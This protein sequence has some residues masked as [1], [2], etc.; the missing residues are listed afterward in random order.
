MKQGAL[1]VLVAALSAASA[2]AREVPVLRARVTDE[3]GVLGDRR[4]ALEERLAAYERAT[5]HQFAVL[6]LRSL[7]GEVL[8]SYS[9]RVAEA[10]RLGDRRRDDGL[11][12]LVAVDDRAARIEVG[13]GLEG[14]VPDV[15]AGRVMREHMIP[16]FKNGDWA[17]G[18]EA[19]LDALMRAAQGEALGPAPAGSGGLGDRERW[20]PIVFFAVIALSVLLRIPRIVRVPFA[21]LLGGFVGFALLKSLLWAAALALGLGLLALVLPTLRG[22]GRHH[23]RGWV[24]GGTSWGGSSGGFGGFSGGGGGFGGGGASGRW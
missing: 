15:I 6:V 24:G 5:G 23:R 20:Q 1:F 22:G 7:E 11:L 14:A 9:V 19:G 4:A 17:G 12:M 18:V 21:I 13:Y 8:E 10:W 16:R 3:A 2:Q